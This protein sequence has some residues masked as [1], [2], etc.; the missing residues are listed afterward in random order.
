MPD[1]IQIG[2]F[3]GATVSDRKYESGDGYEMTRTVKVH[4]GGPPVQTL[5]VIV[6]RDAM[7]VRS[8]AK[9][10]RWNGERWFTVVGMTADE[11]GAKDAPPFSHKIECAKWL[12]NTGD[13]A[14][15]RALE[16]L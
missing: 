9:V 16:V 15:A 8:A 3:S 13:L 6:R 10:E 11:T 4:K 14:L 5:R 1:D 2:K 7:N 12:N